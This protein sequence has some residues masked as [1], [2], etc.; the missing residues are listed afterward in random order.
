MSIGRY[1]KVG[2][3]FSVAA[4]QG[5]NISQPLAGMITELLIAHFLRA[6]QKHGAEER[7]FSARF[8]LRVCPYVLDM[9]A[10]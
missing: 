1:W 2:K 10:V 3:R 5:Q 8:P 6:E 4:Y 7:R 9:H